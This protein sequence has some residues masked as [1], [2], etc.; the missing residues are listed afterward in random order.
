MFHEMKNRKN[1][2]LVES[3]RITDAYIG[4]YR[5]VNEDAF[6]D[7]AKELEQFNN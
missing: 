3:A 4:M 1:K 5:T 2:Y 7:K 6:S